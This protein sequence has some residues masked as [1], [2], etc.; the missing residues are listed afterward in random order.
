MESVDEV[1]H[2]IAVHV[3]QG[4]HGAF[5][6]TFADAYLLADTENEKILRP[7]WKQLIDKYLRR[8]PMLEA[9]V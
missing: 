8:M 2:S 6:S 4:D 5:L 7:V 3:Y 1:L 9:E